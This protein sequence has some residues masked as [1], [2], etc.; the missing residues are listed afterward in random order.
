M[1][2]LIPLI[3]AACAA[4]AEGGDPQARFTASYVKEAAGDY[5]GARQALEPVLRAQPGD[6]L[7][8]LRS[9]WLSYRLGQHQAA[10]TSYQAACTAA[11]NAIEPRLGAMLPLMA[12]GK[13]S[14]VEQQARQVLRQDVGNAS[15]S[16]WLAE[17]LLAQARLRDALDVA[18][19]LAERYPADANLVELVARARAASGNLPQARAA[20]RFLLLLDTRNRAAQD[21]LAKNP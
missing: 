14:E 13:W 5:A 2:I 18:E 16:R 9:G 12:L 21:W 7:A 15:A 17:S 1:R 10:A 11:P 20:Y 6:Y 3:L 4:A 8:N 19:R